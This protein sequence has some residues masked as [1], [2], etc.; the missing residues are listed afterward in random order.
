[1]AS[2]FTAF[3]IGDAD[4]LLATWHPSTRPADL[5]PDDA[6]RWVRLE[7]ID[8]ADGGPF[9]TTGAVEFRAYYRAP[10]GQGV[11]HERSNFLREDGRWLYV[12]GTSSPS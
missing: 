9:D 8:T 5:V 1:M 6:V 3:A 10:G 4:Y 2:R 7:V 11:L 12:N